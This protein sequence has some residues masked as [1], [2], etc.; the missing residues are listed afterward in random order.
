MLTLN[1]Y[2]LKQVMQFAS[3]ALEDLFSSNDV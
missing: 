1:I 3:R 2:Y